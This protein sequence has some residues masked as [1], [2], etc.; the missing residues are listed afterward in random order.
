VADLITRAR[1]VLTAAVTWLVAASAVVTI[2]AEEITEVLPD[3]WQG[4][5]ARTVVVVL[6]VL[7][8]AVNIIRRVTPVLPAQRGL[9]PED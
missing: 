4:P 7:T 9:L 5:F 2:F 8:A 6:A 3:D 1:V